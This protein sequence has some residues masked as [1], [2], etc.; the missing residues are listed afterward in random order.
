MKTKA[1][2]S[3]LTLGLI[4]SAFGQKPALE[5]TFTAIDSASYVQLD[6]IKVINCTQGG[7]T[8]LYWPDTVLVLDY[9]VGITEINDGGE[10]LQVFQNYPNPVKNQTTITLYV[11]EKEKVDVMISDMLGRKVINTERLLDR[12]YHSFRFAPGSGKIF[13][14]TAYWKAT[15]SSIKIM[16]AATGADRSSSL[17]YLGSYSS[18]PY[19]KSFNNVQS[20]EFNLG[21][22]LL[23]I[24]F[25]DTLQSSILD[26][27]ENSETY[28]FQF[29]YNIPCLGTP[30]VTYEG[31]V[32]NTVQIF[33]QC[34]LKKSLNIGTMIYGS[35]NQQNNSTIEKYCYNDIEDSCDIYGG[36]YKW[37]EMMQYVTTEVAQGICPEGW[38]IPTDDEWK[39]LEGTVDSQY[40]VGNPEWGNTLYR[41]FDA[42]L[43]LK[44]V[45]GWYYGGNGIDLYGFKALPGGY[46]YIF[47]YF[48]SLSTSG[49]FWSSTELDTSNAWGRGLFYNYDEVHRTSYSKIYGFS[50]RCLK[51]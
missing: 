24:G 11:P 16:H 1:F 33:S 42:G 31:Q 3:I 30:I 9:Q 17:E 36:L 7:D 40:G 38:H 6:S 22:E 28:T 45:S 47:G 20:F 34:W 37:D 8:L 21:D 10:G 41:G 15:S 12:G 32:Y 25:A 49:L 48:I 46:R 27:P 4:A 39:V 13:F 50:V 44:S 19:L 5:L 29:A 2:L 35:Q 23:Y 14:F 51:D 18:E 26:A 43:N